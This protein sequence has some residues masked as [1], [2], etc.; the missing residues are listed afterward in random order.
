M[1]RMIDILKELGIDLPL[2]M[3]GFSGGFAT[4]MKNKGLSW[5]EKAVV[6]G[7]GGMIANY[8]TPLVAEFINVSENSYLGMAFFVG[9]GGL[10]FTEKVFEIIHVRIEKKKQDETNQ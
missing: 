6:L 9:F 10:K 5:G 1:K 8:I 4:L 7:S 2:I 3:A